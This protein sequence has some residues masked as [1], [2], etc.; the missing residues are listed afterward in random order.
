MVMVLLLKQLLVVWKA[1][2]SMT[3]KFGGYP[4]STLEELV[5]LGFAVA[6][7]TRSRDSVQLDLAIL[8]LLALNFEV[9]TIAKLGAGLE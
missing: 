9:L 6:T 4:E 2:A 1:E 8:K 3:A 5:L 7:K